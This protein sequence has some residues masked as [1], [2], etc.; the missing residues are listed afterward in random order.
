MKRVLTFK[1]VLVVVFSLLLT[2]GLFAQFGTVPKSASF[3]NTTDISGTTI[4]MT[5]GKTYPFYVLPDTYY[6]PSYDLT[7]GSGLTPGFTWVWTVNAALSVADATANDNY[8]EITAGAATG[9]PYA[10]SVIETAPAAMGSCADAGKTFSI[11][12]VAAPI[13]AVNHTGTVEGCAGSAAITAVADVTMT[14]TGT[15]NFRVAYTLQIASLNAVGNPV[16]YYDAAKANPSATAFNAVEYT[17]AVPLAI[18]AATD[19][20]VTGG[21]TVIGTTRTRYTYTFSSINDLVS[22]RGDFVNIATPATATA[23]QFVYYD[24]AGAAAGTATHQ[25]IVIVNPA[26]VTGPIYHIASTWAN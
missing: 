7:D 25:L 13:L 26:P 12:V 10:I 9:G 21:H 14:P 20:M 5:V 17:E 3:D 19:V 1:Q 16:N 23:G 8:V 6:H 4:Q 24:V 22:R 2:N 15:S 18:N 11:S